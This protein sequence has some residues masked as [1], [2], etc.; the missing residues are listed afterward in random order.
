MAVKFDKVK[1]GMT[2]YDRRR[3]QM[4]NTSA[5]SI[6]E[7]KVE[8]ISVDAAKRTATVRWN[9]NR[10]QVYGESSFKSLYDWSMWD[11][12]QATLEKGILGSVIKV[13]RLTKAERNAAKKAASK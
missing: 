5:S 4:G 10:P 1:P 13:R 8:I 3:R 7:F 2:L 12:T 6:D 11:K 9:G